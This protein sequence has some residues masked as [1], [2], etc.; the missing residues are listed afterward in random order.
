M[1]RQALGKGLGALIMKKQETTPTPVNVV[2]DGDSVIQAK[3][4]DIKASPFQ[5]RRHF[6]EEQIQELAASI[7][8]R[9]LIQPLVVRKVNGM[10]ELIAGERRLRAVTSLG[11]ST[12]KVVVH[13]AT[14]QEVAELALIENLQRA[15]LTPLEEAEQYRLLQEKFGMKQETIAQHVGKSRAVIA[16]MVRLLELAP[17]VRNLLNQ[18][19]ITVGHAKV[20]LQLKDAMQQT[21]AAQRVARNTMTVRQT[22]QMV[23]NLLNPQETP[24]REV[25]QLPEAYARVCSQLSRDFGT[26]VNIAMKGKSNGVIEIPYA[27]REELVRILQIFGISESL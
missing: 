7:R 6:D 11:M 3:V 2:A 5:P 27:G 25:P 10:Y 18:Q 8:E 19:Q 16:N 12:V 23:R 14:D 22:E 17:E 20:L 13:E 26:K 24:T 9:G 1:A 4:K 15:D 21:L